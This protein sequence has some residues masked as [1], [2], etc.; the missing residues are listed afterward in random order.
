ME[1]TAYN[2][3]QFQSAGPVEAA[4]AHRLPRS[5]ARTVYVLDRNGVIIETNEV[6]A[7]LTGVPGEQLAGQK[8]AEYL[9][10][11]ASAR[12]AEVFAGTELASSAGI[13]AM[14]RCADGRE[15]PVRGRVVA[16]RE[17]A[18]GF[19]GA[20]VDLERALVWVAPDEG[21]E[22][23]DASELLDLI[24]D[25]V[26]E[27]NSEREVLSINR[28]GR[29]LFGYGAAE[30][31]AGLNL[32]AL[33]VNLGARAIVELADD[34]G[35]TPNATMGRRK[36]GKRFIGRVRVH[37]MNDGDHDGCWR[38]IVSDLSS[39][40]EIERMAKVMEF[41]AGI[42]EFCFAILNRDCKIMYADPMFAGLFG[43]ECAD[44]MTGSPIGGCLRERGP[45]SRSE[46]AENLPSV[47]RALIKLPAKNNKGR[48]KKA[49][50]IAMGEYQL[51]IVSAH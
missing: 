42:G 50:L 15:R 1:N 48:A 51:V 33:F 35:L 45:E 13:E 18:G 26:I 12:L 14:I 19:S 29:Q 36:D 8:L 27:V 3:N 23:S 38:L 25:A 7:P 49:S 32:D 31:R 37:R 47:A 39:H 34:H 5:N 11:V 28:A 30:C 10:P 46:Q 2:Q 22:P 20:V 40:R 6:I 9:D 4:P 44:A 21:P 43:Y 16:I 17:D 41:A 24:S